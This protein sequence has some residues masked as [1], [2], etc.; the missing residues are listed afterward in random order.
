MSARSAPTPEWPQVSNLEAEQALLGAL[1][2]EN[3]A[4][5]SV[6][7]YLLP[8][9]FAE[10]LHGR[11]YAAIV[12]RLSGGKLADPI[13]VSDAMASDAAYHELGGLKYLGRLLAQAPPAANAAD[14]AEAIFDTAIRRDLAHICAEG[15]LLASEGEGR[16]FGLVAEVRK[17]LEAVET[18]AAPEETLVAAPV[19]ARRAIEAMEERAVSGKPRG[20][21]TGLRCID[22]RANGLKPNALIVI[23]G[24][25]G[26]CKTGLA[27][28]IAHG[29][30]VHNPNH[31]FP[32]LNLEMDGVEVMQRELSALT[33]ERGDPV[34]YRAMESGT[35]TAS[36]FSAIAGAE[37]LVPANL[38][39][40]D[41]CA[42]L[43]VEDVRRKVWSLSRRGRVGAVFIDYLQLMRRPSAG[44]RNEASVIAEMTRS[45]K[46]LAVDAG[47]C[48]VLLSQLSRQVENREDKRPQL[49]DLRESGSI[50]QDADLALFPWREFYYLQKAEPKSTNRDKRLEWEMQCEQ[51]RRNLDVICLKQRGGP[52]GVDHQRYYAEYDFIEDGEEVR[53]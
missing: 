51:V 25:P 31:L 16:A 14:Y 41:K 8:A 45:L 36:D 38:I 9:H 26:M 42:N 23:G 13:T 20:L 48:V 40:D 7:G 32:F 34:E 47:V 5:A 11:L 15:L 30:A 4:Y 49:S 1:L 24:R 35:L 39:L 53:R 52:E 3:D 43:A 10:P 18:S 46:L 2:M 50:E 44:G 12:G 27:R 22:R 29:A 6:A 28:A 37:H 19:V 33:Y 17:N 21:M